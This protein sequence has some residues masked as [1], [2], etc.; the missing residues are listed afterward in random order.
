MRGEVDG[1]AEHAVLWL[2]SWNLAECCARRRFLFSSTHERKSPLK[3]SQRFSSNPSCSS[4]TNLE[5]A[6]HT[7]AGKS[8]GFWCVAGSRTSNLTATANCQCPSSLSLVNRPSA[9]CL[10]PGG[11]PKRCETAIE[12]MAMRMTMRIRSISLH[13]RVSCSLL[14]LLACARCSM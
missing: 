13:E 2:I 1:Q 10:K 3:R 5:P 14:R 8:G 11:L 7:N 12:K 6:G 4:G 9:S